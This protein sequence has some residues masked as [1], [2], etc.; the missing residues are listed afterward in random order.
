MV[1]FKEVNLEAVKI[2]YDMFELEKKSNY[3]IE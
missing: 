3:V 1:K 2:K